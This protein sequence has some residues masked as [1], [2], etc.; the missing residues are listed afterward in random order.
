M[1]CFSKSNLKKAKES[2]FENCILLVV[3]HNHHAVDTSLVTVPY[4]WNRLFAYFLW[5]MTPNIST[6]K[7]GNYKCL[8]T[9]SQ[10][11]TG[12]SHL[13][14]PKY[15]NKNILI[16]KKKPKHKKSVM[17]IIH[18]HTCINHAFCVNLLLVH[19]GLPW[20]SS[21]LSVAKQLRG[22]ICVC[23]QITSDTQAEGAN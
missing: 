17:V 15:N 9:E 4:L 2:S 19:L 8:K 16:F 5:N 10:V 11:F 22:E 18:S 3:C 21:P 12:F 14:A 23:G 6:V 20:L 7:I 13:W 1:D